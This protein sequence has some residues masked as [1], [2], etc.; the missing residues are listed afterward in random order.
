MRDSLLSLRSLRSLPEAIRLRTPLASFSPRWGWILYTLVCCCLF[1]LLTFPTD[2]LVQ[3]T[4]ASATRGL[5]MRIQYSQGELTW[6]GAC[7]FRDV[8]IENLSPGFPALK[9][10]RLR[11]HPSLLGLLIGRSFPLTFSADLYEGTASGTIARGTEGLT[12]QLSVRRVALGSLPL[13]LPWGQGSIVGSLTGD[14]DFHGNFS[15]L[16]SLRGTF[17]LDLTG[18]ALRGG[19]TAGFPIPPLAA[20][21]SH[22]RAAL[23]AERLEIA[24]LSLNADGVEA[25]LQGTVVLGTP[26]ARSGLDLQLV[27]KTSGTLPSSLT[28]LLSFIPASPGM[29]GER[30]ASITG[31][32]AAPIVR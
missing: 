29:P 28:M 17:T 7:V 3:R 24:D 2:L 12:I 10:V 22:L 20:V 16:R 27:A 5:P 8:A 31:A 9:L 1:V 26:L 23:K 19:A 25:H 4:V 13:P 11:V 32:L 18:G 6:W 21:Q 14:G 30:R 15:D